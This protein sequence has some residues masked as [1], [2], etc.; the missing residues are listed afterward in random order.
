MPLGKQLGLSFSRNTGSQLLLPFERPRLV[1]LQCVSGS[2]CKWAVFQ[3]GRKWPRLRGTIRAKIGA[4][5]PAAELTPLDDRAGLG[6]VRERIVQMQRE[7]HVAMGRASADE[8]EPGTDGASQQAEELGAG[9][10]QQHDEEEAEP[11]KRQ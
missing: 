11:A 1:E 5:I 8:A 7:L 9:D 6:L 4:P 2:D 3:T 10:R